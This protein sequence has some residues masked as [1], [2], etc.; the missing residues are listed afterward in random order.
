MT[1]AHVST[2]PGSLECLGK[3]GV[4]L[5]RCR[6]DHGS[7]RCPVA[8][9]EELPTRFICVG[10]GKTDTFLCESKTGERGGWAALSYCWG[11]TRCLSTRTA[12]LPS[13]KLGIPL[14]T[15]PK[16]CRDAV[17][18]ARS[19]KIHY[20]WIDALCIVQDSAADWDREAARMCYV[21]EHA[22]VTLA[23]L[24]SDNSDKGLFLP[25]PDR[26]TVKLEF[27][28]DGHVGEIFVRRT[29]PDAVF[30]IHRH[31]NILPGTSIGNKTIL[32]TR[33][34]T[35]QEL[36]SSP[37]ILWFDSAEIGWSCWSS[38]ACECQPSPTFTNLAHDEEA[39]NAQN[40]RISSSPTLAGAR[41]ID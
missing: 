8:I 3:A 25:N 35:P 16:N 14:A 28:L 15:L 27:D 30:P 17:L 31:R 21:Y 10:D 37:R 34:W 2:D 9:G 6:Q 11:K 26:K 1:A 41:N 12:S 19:L 36:L 23:A 22:V 4:W 13:H 32:G 29:L 5:D 33:V 18:V 7:F 24:D 40:L 20:L 38:T 39:I